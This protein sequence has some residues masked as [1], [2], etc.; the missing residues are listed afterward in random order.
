MRRLRTHAIYNNDLRTLAKSFNDFVDRQPAQI[1]LYIYDPEKQ[2]AVIICSI[3]D[4]TSEQ[5]EQPCEALGSI[6]S[7]TQE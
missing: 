3:V 6:I 4:E 5:S 2:E 7:I 1:E